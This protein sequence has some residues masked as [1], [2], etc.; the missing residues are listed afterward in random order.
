MIFCWLGVEVRGGIAQFLRVDQRNLQTPTIE[1]ASAAA[2][3]GALA[4]QG[5]PSR[6]APAAKRCSD[7]S[8]PLSDLQNLGLWRQR[9]PRGSQ[10][11]RPSWGLRP[12]PARRLD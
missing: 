12:V 3:D 6:T 5:Y 2:R 1:Q 8:L 10:M 4:A 9:F 11:K 7:L